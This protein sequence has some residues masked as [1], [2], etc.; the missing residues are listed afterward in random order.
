M[1]NERGGYEYFDVTKVF[2]LNKVSV[3]YIIGY[4]FLI[5]DGFCFLFKFFIKASTFLA[6]KHPGVK[7]GMVNFLMSKLASAESLFI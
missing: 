2:I 5:E 4:V 1:P 3:N 6:S 7:V